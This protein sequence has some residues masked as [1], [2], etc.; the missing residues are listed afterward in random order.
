MMRRR[1]MMKVMMIWQHN[2]ETL[3]LTSFDITQLKPYLKAFQEQ[4]LINNNNDN[5]ENNN[6]RET[7]ILQNKLL[8]QLYTK[9]QH[10]RAIF[11]EIVEVDEKLKFKLKFMNERYNQCIKQNDIFSKQMIEKDHQINILTR[12]INKLR[13]MFATKYKIFTDGVIMRLHYKYNK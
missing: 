4:I 8:T 2:I 9:N 7:A 13:T 6:L 5:E 12:E 10:Q 1:M 3:K 11:R